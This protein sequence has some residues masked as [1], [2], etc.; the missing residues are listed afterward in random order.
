MSK[1]RSKKYNMHTARFTE[2]KRVYRTRYAPPF[3]FTELSEY[4]IAFSKL[5]L[6]FPSYEMYK[7]FE[8][9]VPSAQA[10]VE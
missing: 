4:P 5:F 7:R 9:A 8:A 2:L 6:P 10:L 3:L 1:V